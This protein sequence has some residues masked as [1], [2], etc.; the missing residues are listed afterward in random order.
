MKE[1]QP[2]VYFFG[3]IE[4]CSNM[5][6]GGD[7][8]FVE[9]AFEYGSKWNKIG[10]IET[11]QTQS[12][13]VD[14]D[15]YVCFSHPFKAHFSTTS[16]LGWPKLTAKIYKLDETDTIDLLSYGTLNLPNSPG[17]HECTF[18][19]WAL[20]GNRRQETFTYYLDAKPIMT[21]NDPI[22]RKT[23]YREFLVTKPGP[24]IHVNVEV[25]LKNFKDNQYNLAKN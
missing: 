25:L 18:D 23:E 22:T 15:D 17:Y 16:F 1:N 20:H 11:F 19:T 12:G 3:Q 4:G 5:K 2:E 7:G 8:V 21:S 6:E 9:A 10:E 24:K 13:Y 14:D